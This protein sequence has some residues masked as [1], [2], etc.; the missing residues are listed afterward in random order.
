MLR[1]HPLNTL[2]Q[3]R[4]VKDCLFK[5]IYYLTNS[6]NVL[7]LLAAKGPSSLTVRFQSNIFI[8]TKQT[9]TRVRYITI[10]LEIVIP[11]LVLM[12]QVRYIAFRYRLDEPRNHCQFNH[13]VFHGKQA[14]FKLNEFVEQVLRIIYL[15]LQYHMT[16][17]QVN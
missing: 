17:R 4:N 8:L 1:K 16:S 9:S 15:L 12:E 3:K 5:N 2:T 10:L 14:R 7:I 6:M 11:A 13:F